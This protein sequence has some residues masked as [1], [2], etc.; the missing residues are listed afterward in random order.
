MGRLPFD[1]GK[2]RGAKPPKAAEPAPAE[3]V[4]TVSR[5]AAM[6]STVVGDHLPARVRVVG[7][8]SG[9]RRSTH[10][11]FGL[12]DAGALISAAVFASNLRKLG[13][14]PRDG[15]Q[16]VA[17]GRVEFYE[18][19]GRITLIVEAIEPVGQG[20]HELRFKQLCEE[21]RRL[22]WFAAERKRP[23]PTFP[24]KVA[25][26]TSRT[27]AALQDVLD[28]MARRCP[29]VGVVLV[30]VKVQGEGAAEQVVRALA[31]LAANHEK[32]GIDAVI[33]T[34]GGG[35]PEDLDAFNEREVARAIVQCPVP[36]VAAIGHETDT[37]IAELV[38]DERC[39]TPTQAAM[40][41]TPDRDALH[42]Q[43]DALANR[44]RTDLVRTIRFERQRLAAAARHPVLADP[45]GATRLAG[46]QMGRTRDR[47]ADAI[48]GAL[49]H[50]ERG[51]E[52]S[53]G[54][55]ARVQ[56]RR[57]L[58]AAR[59]ASETGSLRLRRAVA[60]SLAADASR[61]VACSQHLES[62]GPGAVLRR[63]YSCTVR[64][65]GRV[66]RDAAELSIGERLT[67]HLAQGSFQADVASTQPGALPAPIPA[68]PRADKPGP[69]R[70]AGSPQPPARDQ[71]DLFGGAG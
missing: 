58:D 9:A 41:L 24:R 64:P 6:I 32:L 62:V 46:E 37:T 3:G 27:G 59:A 22:G 30:P 26:V 12:K 55:L 23:L 11:Y 39:A 5:L 1:P 57:Q 14:E 48:H 69:T 17:T 10:L 21:L 16:I 61:V 25:V 13:F 20:A 67:T 33:V 19:Q 8:V 65:D 71:L 63:G 31:H 7:E 54:A 18:P 70:P 29:A 47:L 66:V 35:S 51:T 56:P 52:R 2:M 38:A 28:T 53:H 60:T 4:L 36:V 49:D 44:C 40:R 45:R 43:L 68:R 34:R 42:R 15:Q 50:A